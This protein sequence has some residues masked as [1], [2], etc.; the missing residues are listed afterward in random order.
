M[1]LADADLMQH[2][3]NTF[4][5]WLGTGDIKEGFFQAWYQ[6]PDCALVKAGGTKKVMDDE[7]WI[8]WFLDIFNG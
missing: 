1:R 3:P 4:H 8:L 5:H 6:F 2:F 7:V